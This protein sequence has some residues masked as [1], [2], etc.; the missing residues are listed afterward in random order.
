MRDVNQALAAAQRPVAAPPGRTRRAF[1]LGNT[2]KL[3]EE[4]LNV[5]LESPLYES[6]CVGVRKT[7]RSH[8]PRLESLAVPADIGGWN[9]AAGMQRAPDDLYLCIEPAAKSFWRI[10]KPFVAITSG[11]ATGIACRMR[12]SGARRI[13]IVTPLEAIMQI[14]SA[15]AI[16]NPDEMEIVKAGFERLLVLRP[17]EDR[18]RDAE[19]G[20]M[21]S[22]GGMVT[23]ALV[24]YM[25]P[26][27]LQ[28]V[29]VRRAAQVAVET[30]ATMADGVQV[31]GAARLRELVGDPLG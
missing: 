13:A 28:P 30:L 21:G 23:G 6:V 26:K 27:G 2:G 1:I 18:Q 10:A 12:A 24:S 5:L 15:P 17:T 7:M 20:V 3:G 11:Q 19:E 14:G 8:V 9:P 31:V 16:H 22:V 29:R 4:L 25:R